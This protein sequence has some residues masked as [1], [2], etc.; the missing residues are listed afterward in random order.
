MARGPLAWQTGVRN[1]MGAPEVLGRCRGAAEAVAAGISPMGYLHRRVGC[2]GVECYWTIVQPHLAAVLGAYVCACHFLR[3]AACDLP[4]PPG[5]RGV[6]QQQRQLV[7]PAGQP[8][9]I[10]TWR[11]R[12]GGVSTEA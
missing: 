10:A 6:P 11:R 9:Q 12:G 8:A 2:A 1:A 5:R 4:P 7:R 3:T